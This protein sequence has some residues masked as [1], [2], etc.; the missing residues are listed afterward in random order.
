M[1]LKGITACCKYQLKNLLKTLVIYF[2]WLFGILF[3]SAA[4]NSIVSGV[5]FTFEN[6]SMECVD[7]FTGIIVFAML[8]TRTADFI[9]T[10]AANGVSRASVSISL[11]ISSIIYSAAAALESAVMCPLISLITGT[12]EVCMASIYGSQEL[13]AQNGISDFGI[14]LRFFLVC[15]IAY[16]AIAA[17]GVLLRSISYRFPQWLSASII[18]LIGFIPTLGIYFTFGSEKLMQF[19]MN[20]LL[21]AGISVDNTQLGNIGQGTLF[22]LGGFIIMSIITAI[23][24]HR[25]SV[26]TSAFK[27]NS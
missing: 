12:P 3:L 27:V 24:L 26:K 11:A 13:L 8:T 10:A 21:A 9:N 2:I 5:S 18:I 20:V 7:G 1:S 19:W 23:I 25:S 14:R 16:S 22:F 4:L 15:F 17:S 6:I